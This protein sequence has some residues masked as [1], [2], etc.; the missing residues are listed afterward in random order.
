[1]EEEDDD[2]A[3]MEG[4]AEEQGEGDGA[5]EKVFDQSHIKMTRLIYLSVR[6]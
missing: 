6:F 5:A 3:E 4:D 2:D 1:M